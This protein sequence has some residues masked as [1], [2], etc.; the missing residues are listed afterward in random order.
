MLPPKRRRKFFPPNWT[1]EFFAERV[2]FPEWTT[3][4]V[5]RDPFYKKPVYTYAGPPRGMLRVDS[6]PYP[7]VAISEI[8]GDPVFWN[9]PDEPV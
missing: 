8:S 5:A 7:H 2:S 1:N 9:E 6:E 4:T 3:T